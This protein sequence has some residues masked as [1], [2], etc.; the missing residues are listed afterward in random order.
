L[1]AWREPQSV[2]TVFCVLAAVLVVVR[3][4]TNLRRLWSGNEN[5]LKE[6]K[7]MLF[8]SKTL[9]VLAVGLWFGTMVFFTLSGVLMF[10]AF[11]EESRKDDDRELWF[12][13]PEAM[14]KAPPSPRFP[15]P[16]R[17]EQGLRAFG[18]AVAPL[19]RW[20]YGI[21]TGCAVVAFGTA[22]GWSLK[23]GCGWL[24]FVRACLLG[25]ALLTVGVGCWLENV[26][27]DKRG[28]RNE[29]TDKVILKSH[30]T[31][32]E[33]DAAGLARAHFGLWHGFSLLQNFTTLLLV[34]AAMVLAAHLPAAETVVGQAA[35]RDFE[36]KTELLPG[37]SS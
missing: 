29:L 20:Y 34:T 37:G 24:N 33:L 1:D 11:K 13:I 21:Q 15:N 31:Q 7:T 28:P 14:K 30:P 17:E 26:V 12:P 5:R 35:K 8:V 25:L 2:V 3:H 6:S 10:E 9:H 22:L 36:G 19:F 18:V 4:R 23:R 16:L 32:E 27:A